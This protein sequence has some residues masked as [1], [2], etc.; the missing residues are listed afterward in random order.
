MTEHIEE[1]QQ[2]KSKTNWVRISLY[3]IAFLIVL[4]EVIP[5]GLI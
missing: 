5:I 3:L 2:V 4:P 1:Q